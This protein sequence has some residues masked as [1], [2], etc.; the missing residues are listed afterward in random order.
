MQL[1]LGM[2]KKLRHPV[3]APTGV[4]KNDGSMD[5]QGWL[6]K[7]KMMHDGFGSGPLLMLQFLGLLPQATA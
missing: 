3:V 2:I 4:G 6:V 7:Q 5:A 1:W